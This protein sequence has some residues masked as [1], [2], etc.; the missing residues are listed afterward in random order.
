M[1]ELLWI[2]SGSSKALRTC[3]AFLVVSVLHASPSLLR[4]IIVIMLFSLHTFRGQSP[5][6]QAHGNESV[7]FKACGLRGVSGQAP[8]PVAGFLSVRQGSS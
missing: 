5:G 3:D 6:V 4:I 7:P 8:P 2:C 1:D